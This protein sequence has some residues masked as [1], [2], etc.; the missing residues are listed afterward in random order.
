[1]SYRRAHLQARGAQA[2]PRRLRRLLQPRPV[3]RPSPV[4]R[5][6]LVIGGAERGARRTSLSS[7]LHMCVAYPG[8]AARH[9]QLGRLLMWVFIAIRTFHSGDLVNLADAKISLDSSQNA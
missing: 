5:A 4:F 3:I 2:R 9:F 8:A 7:T 1:M 6:P